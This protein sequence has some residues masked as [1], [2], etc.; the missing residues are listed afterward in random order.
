MP[1]SIAGCQT[2]KE[3]RMGRRVLSACVMALMASLVH[4][5]EEPSA[6][7]VTGGDE[8]VK[9]RGFFR[10]TWVRPDADI[11][12]Y[13]KLKL[14]EPVFQFRDVGEP[15]GPGTTRAQLLSSGPYPVSQESKDRFRQVVVDAFVEELQRSKRFELVDELGPGT[16]IVRGG[17]LDI[18][19]SV[20]PGARLRDAHLAAVGE[21]TFVFQLI[22]A[23]S[24]IIQAAIGERRRIQP[25]G[26]H[27][28][29]FA[30]PA[31]A[32]TVWADVEQWAHGFVADFRR[33]LD[34]ARNKAETR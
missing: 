1:P 27:L 31:N 13:D 3:E 32:A 8:L 24:G 14:W 29:M 25:P 20:P 9:E 33:E 22:D 11:T 15:G 23:N 21:G 30:R 18:V 6:A 12:R 16:L 5:Q 26:A 28:D 19:S 10:E 34:K 2:P 4:A 7:P 17:I